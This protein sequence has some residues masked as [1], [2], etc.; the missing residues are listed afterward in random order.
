MTRIPRPTEAE[1]AILR[2][3]WE[4]GP[5]TVRQVNERLSAGT[6]RGVGYT[7][8]LKLMQIMADKGL[9]VRDESDRTHVYAARA[10]QDQTQRQLVSDLMDKAFGGSAAALVL[11]ALSAHPAP[12]AELEEI[13]RLIGEYRRTGKI[14]KRKVGEHNG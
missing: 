9:V 14:G 8:T 10:S 2:V 1:L 6:A 5:A 3:L 7:T 13:Q 11:Q 12:A 4:A